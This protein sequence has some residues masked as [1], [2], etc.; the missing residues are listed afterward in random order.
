V[1]PVIGTIDS[2][3]AHGIMEALL[4]AITERRSRF[5]VL[6]L[7]GVENIDAAT[8]DHLLKVMGAIRLLGA[9][10]I[11]CGIRPQVAQILTEIEVDLS[12]VVTLATLHEALAYC[13]SRLSARGR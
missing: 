6:D 12:S 13:I 3:R 8:A 5:A 9:Q 2:E 1:V 10:G 11:F 7:T 4:F